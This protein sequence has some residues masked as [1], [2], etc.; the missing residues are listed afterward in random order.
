MDIKHGA[1]VYVGMEPHHAA[2]PMKVVLDDD[3]CRWLCDADVD[4]DK[5]LKEQGCWRCGDLAFTRDD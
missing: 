2:R 1:R 3:G 4:E 5:D